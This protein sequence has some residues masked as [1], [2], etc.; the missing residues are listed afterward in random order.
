MDKSQKWAESFGLD[1]SPSKTE[2]MLCIRQKSKSYH[3]PTDG[4]KFKG[5]ELERSA[6]VKYLGLT[7][8]HRLNWGE[9]INEKVKAVKRNIFRLK[10]FIGKTWGP[11]PEMTK[12]AY[13]STIRPAMLY[14]S[15]AFA[16]GLGL[17]LNSVQSL[18]LRMTC[19]AR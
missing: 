17:Q 16:R 8:E 13:T 6:S 5:V 12:L 4:I 1:I 18:A 11:C 2:Y 14:A 9:H 15:F 10:G 3:I 19:N 7:I